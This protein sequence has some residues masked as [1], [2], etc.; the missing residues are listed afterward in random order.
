VSDDPTVRYA[1]YRINVILAK[2]KG[3]WTGD[4]ILT[5]SDGSDVDYSSYQSSPVFATRE[6][7]ERTVISVAKFVIDRMSRKL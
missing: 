7:A 1:G 4:F 6:E 5:R 3:G 2:V